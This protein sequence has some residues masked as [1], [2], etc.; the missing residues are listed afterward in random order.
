MRIL[1]THTPGQTSAYSLSSILDPFHLRY[2]C[3]QSMLFLFMPLLLY[4]VHAFSVHAATAL[5]SP[6]FFCSC[7]YCSTQSMLFLFMPLLLYA[8]HAFSVHAPAFT[9]LRGVSLS[10]L[11][12]GLRSFKLRIRSVSGDWNFLEHSHSPLVPLSQMIFTICHQLPI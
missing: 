3:T 1:A 8:V 4:T 6:C 11:Q 12:E 10:L 2:C 5:H 9:S 7:R